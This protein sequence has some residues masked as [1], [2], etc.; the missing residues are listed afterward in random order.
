[1][2]AYLTTD[3]TANQA[4]SLLDLTRLFVEVSKL[5]DLLFGMV[6]FEYEMVTSIGSD[7]GFVYWGV[8]LIRMVSWFSTIMGIGALIALIMSSG[9][10]QSLGGQLLVGG[11][12]LVG[13]A[14]TALGAG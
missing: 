9:I 14:T 10:M 1:M 4:G 3:Y 5:G 2:K 11:S 13:A 8:I 12:L 7:E 6:A